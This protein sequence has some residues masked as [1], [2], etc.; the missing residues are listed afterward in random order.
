MTKDEAARKLGL[1]VYDCAL[2]Q[3]WLDEVVLKLR[4]IGKV[5]DPDLYHKL[6]SG[7]VWCYDGNSSTGFPRPL[8][9]QALEWLRKF[10]EIAHTHLTDEPMEVI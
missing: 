10:D 8:T 3:P 6:L 4:L 5:E 9:Q 7:I 2:P 1:E